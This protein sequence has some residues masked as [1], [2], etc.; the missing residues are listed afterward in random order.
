MSILTR[1]LISIKLWLMLLCS[2]ITN[3]CLYAGNA[4]LIMNSN[5]AG[6][7]LFQR[8]LAPDHL[9]GRA[10]GTGIPTQRFHQ[11]DV[12]INRAASYY[13]IDPLFVKAILLV[14]SSLNAHALSK[15]K[16]CG[17]AQFMRTT[18]D[19]V[20]IDNRYD[21]IT[22]IWGCAALLRRHCHRFKGN[23]IL[24]AAAYNAG[25]GSIRHGRIPHIHE[26]EHYVP[27][28]LWTWERMHRY[29]Q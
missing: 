20:G 6:Q 24:M 25:P 3:D 9:L 22:S 11:Y 19:A 16:A 2:F 18:A 28:G 21:P 8:H 4:N 12:T 26:T 10:H 1:D 15:A 5:R 7:I 17:I 13:Q 23:M 14:E 27:K 29:H